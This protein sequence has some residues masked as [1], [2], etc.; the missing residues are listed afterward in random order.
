M[1][2]QN[3][4]ILTVVAV[5]GAAGAV[6]RYA[7]SGWA[8]QLLGTRFAY[9]TLAV[10]LIGCLLL[11]LL[12]HLMTTTEAVS[13]TTRAALGIGFLGAFTT[14]ST[15]GWETFQYLE[16][17]AWPAAAGNVAANVLLGLAAVWAGVTIGRIWLGGA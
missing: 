16:D 9:G 5:F 8:H 4:S 7:V 13:P 2:W 11:G 17:G 1:S 14:F 12:G 10:N 6:A 15:F 3:L